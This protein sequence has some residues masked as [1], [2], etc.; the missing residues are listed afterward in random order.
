MAGLIAG[1]GGVLLVRAAV[2]SPETTDSETISVD[3]SEPPVTDDT[4]VSGDPNETGSAEGTGDGNSGPATDPSNL[5]KP[6]EIF[7]DTL[8]DLD[9]D[10]VIVD[11]TSVD[12]PQVPEI[13]AEVQSG[14]VQNGRIT[15]NLPDGFYWGVLVNTFDEEERGIN[16]DIR[17]AFFGDACRQRF[18]D[19]DDSCNNDY[20]VT[21]FDG[22]QL[23]PSFLSDLLFVSLAV[24]EQPTGQNTAIVPATYWSLINGGLPST[25]S[26]PGDNSDRAT[27]LLVGTPYLL[28]IVDGA[29]IAAEGIWAP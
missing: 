22:N 24:A 15:I 19:T 14:W 9:I 25:V 1:V 10:Q 16:F 13:T 27:A 21:P 23:Y 17:Q 8:G 6:I 7:S 20:G 18:G 28:T 4:S 3:G 26:I 12:A 29:I 11:W 5:G 2:D